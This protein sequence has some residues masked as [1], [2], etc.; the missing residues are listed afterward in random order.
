M[1]KGHHRAEP[2]DPAPEYRDWVDHR[3][4]PGYFVG[5]RLSPW[6]RA[7]QDVV[8]DSHGGGRTF[9]IVCLTLALLTFAGGAAHVYRSGLQNIQM[10]LAGALVALVPLVAGVSALRRA[11][12]R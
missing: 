12:R 9:G 10:V 2:P 4:T 6:V 7:L 3:Y 11:R 8:R 5:G 1:R